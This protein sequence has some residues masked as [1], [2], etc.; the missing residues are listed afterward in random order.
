MGMNHGLCPSNVTDKWPTASQLNYIL[1]NKRGKKLKEAGSGVK[2]Y[3]WDA[4]KNSS[5]SDDRIS[6]IEMVWAHYKN[7]G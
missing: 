2:Q 4:V 5:Q 1:K 7:W 6:I 3:E